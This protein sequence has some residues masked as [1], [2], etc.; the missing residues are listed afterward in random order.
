MAGEPLRGGGR[1]NGAGGAAEVM[2]FMGVAGALKSSGR[3]RAPAM[4]PGTRPAVAPSSFVTGNE[5]L[6]ACPTSSKLENPELRKKLRALKFRDWQRHGK[7]PVAPKF[8]GEIDSRNSSRAHHIPKRP[9]GLPRARRARCTV[10]GRR[11]VRLRPCRPRELLLPARLG[12]RAGAD[13]MAPAAAAATLERRA[14][15]SHVLPRRRTP[16]LPRLNAPRS[17]EG[18]TPLLPREIADPCQRPGRA[19]FAWP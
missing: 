19:R 17:P 3:R 8:P 11:Q 14:G 9:R 4:Q 18:A 1:R 13:G 16:P 2:A 5:T 7:V 12:R 15:R 10:Q 6:P